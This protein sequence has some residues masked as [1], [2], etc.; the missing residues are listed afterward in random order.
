MFEFAAI[1]GMFTTFAGLIGKGIEKFGSNSC[2]SKPH[3]SEEEIKEE[4]RSTYELLKIEREK[5]L[6]WIEEINK[7]YGK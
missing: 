2:Y 1:V 3:S 4:A 5:T 6:Q 7:K